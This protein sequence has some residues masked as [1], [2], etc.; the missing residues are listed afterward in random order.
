MNNI[1]FNI[2]YTC[3]D[4]FKNIQH[5]IKNPT[6]V[7]NN[8]YTHKCKAW[9]DEHY[10]EYDAFLTSS[11]TRALE[12]VAMYLNLKPNDEIIL[13][14]FNF[15]GV[16][17]AF[18][19]FGAKLVF[20]DINPQTMNLD[21]NLIEKSITDKTRAIVAMHYAGFTNNIYKIKD[22]CKKYNLIL[23]EDNAQGLGASF[24]NKSLGSFGDFS[25][26]S[27]DAM[28]NIS[29]NEG[30]VLL[31]KKKY[32]EKI[33]VIYNIGTNK[34]DFLTGKVEFYSWISKGSKF[35]MS[36]YNAAILY[37]LLIKLKTIT[38]KR[39]TIWN[40]FYHQL[41]SIL[42]NKIQLPQHLFQS[43]EHNAHIFYIL[44]QD[45]K[46]RSLVSSVLTK[47]G[48]P[49]HIHYIPLNKSTRN[50]KHF[51]TYTKINKC[52]TAAGQ[53]LR[54]PM[55]NYLTSSQIAYIAENL[56]KIC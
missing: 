25:C 9:F 41:S 29:C 27:F 48:I 35:Y 16:A 34:L 21:E 17:N 10:S 49:N 54:L 5:L 15:V 18:V 30:G 56:F 55:H 50:K 4:S 14:P 39:I 44:L 20:V 24:Q 38:Q 31:C 2:P 42:E 37:P 23:I 3:S 26:I 46:Q 6:I 8:T 43:N 52:N 45:S 53:L 51:T 22:I 1:N 33:D 7:N 13:S 36:E 47:S 32:T 19:N 12:L 40:K 11:A 28:K